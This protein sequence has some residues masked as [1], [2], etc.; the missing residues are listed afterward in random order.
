METTRE[1]LMSLGVRISSDGKRR[2]PDDLKARLVA[3]T[4]LPGA[5][6]NAVAAKYDIGANH[7]SS[8]RRMAKDGLLVLPVLEEETG[9]APLVVFDDPPAARP[10]DQ[11]KA[12]TGEIEI[13]SGA[14]SVKLDGATSAARISEIVSALRAGA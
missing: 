13:V 14:I 1:F 7:L 12:A 11:S 3:E 9:F 5:S 2:W 8:W 6:V 4:L 10:A